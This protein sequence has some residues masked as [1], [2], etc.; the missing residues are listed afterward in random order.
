LIIRR[1]LVYSALT[2]T[3]A[4]VYFASVVL[5][6][7]LLAAAGVTQSAFVVVISTLVIAAL[8]TPLRQRIQFDI[9]RRFY[10]QRYDI[11]KT[12]SAFTSLVSEQVD[13]DELSGHLLAVIEETMQPE[14][15]G[16]WLAPVSLSA[17]PADETE[18]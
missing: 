7:S 10:R 14:F 13:L 4:V 2:A 16:M 9:D 3:L 12:L 11:E 18:E 17:A 5:M 8:F 15:V 6:Q 1:T